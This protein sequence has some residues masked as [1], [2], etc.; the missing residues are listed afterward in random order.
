MDRPLVQ[1]RVFQGQIEPLYS[2]I[3]TTLEV[4]KPVF[5]AFG[6]RNVAKA[7]Q[8]LTQAGYSKAN[9]LKLEFWYRSNL[10]NDQLAVTTLR[11]IAHKKLGDLMQIDLK[12]VESTTAYK[13][14]DKGAYPIF[15]LDWSPDFLDPDNYIQPF[16]ECTKGAADTG[17]EDGSSFL[18]GSFY[19]S[20]RVNQLIN[21]SRREQNPAIR[22]QLFADLQNQLAKDVPFI[23]LWQNKDYLFAQKTIQ[24]AT[25]EATQ[26]V[27]FS[28]LRKL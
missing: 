10:V 28:T 26:K 24:G 16:M 5:E 15:L 27:P 22:K 14:L 4:Q 9:P 7:T 1:D 19:Y 20:D 2:L 6:D 17:C 3:P 18:Q 11:A 23:P 13:N 21:Q 12:S 8:L 25:L